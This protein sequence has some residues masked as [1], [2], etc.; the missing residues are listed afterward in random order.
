MFNIDFSKYDNFLSQLS[1]IVFFLV[2][3]I[4]LT[5]VF[6]LIPGLASAQ[7][8][9]DPNTVVLPSFIPQWVAYVVVLLPTLV[10]IFQSIARWTKN[11]W[12]DEAVNWFIKIIRMMGWYSV[13]K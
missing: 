6:V 12:D 8:I 5:L 11:T 1:N 9:A 4:L 10:L 7:E 3:S 2:F 13:K